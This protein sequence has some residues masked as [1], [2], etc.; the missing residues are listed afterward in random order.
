MTSVLILFLLFGILSC[1][2]ANTPKPRG[3]FRIDFPA[4]EYHS[5]PDGHPFRF[6]LPTYAELSLYDGQITDEGQIED[7]LNV[8]FPDLM[9]NEDM[10]EDDFSLTP[11]LTCGCYDG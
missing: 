7:W 9:E 3:Y 10:F 1:Q 4:K 8:D 6:L 2:N 11:E 5:I